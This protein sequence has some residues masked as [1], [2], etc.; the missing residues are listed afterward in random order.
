[1]SPALAS[2]MLAIALAFFAFTMFAAWLRS[3]RFGAT[4]NGPRR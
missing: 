4:A 1:M 3:L 2:A